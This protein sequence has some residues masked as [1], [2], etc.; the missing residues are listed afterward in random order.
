MSTAPSQV[1]RTRDDIAA[2][3]SRTL[4][5]L[6]EPGSVFEIRA[7]RTPGQGTVSGYYTDIAKCARDVAERLDGKAPAVY[8]TPNPVQ[9]DVAARAFNR[10]K[11]RADVTTQDSEIVRRRWLLIDPDP[12]RPPGISASEAEHAEALAR[13]EAI[14]EFLASEGWP[15]PIRADS[16]NGAHLLY[17]IDLPNDK[18]SAALVAGVLHALARAFDDAQV[19]VDTSVANAARIWKLYPTLVCKGDSTPRR[20]HRR[21][22]LLSAPEQPE[23]VTR[24]TLVALCDEM[25]VTMPPQVQVR[26]GERWI[27]DANEYLRAHGIEVLSERIAANARKWVLRACVWNPNHTDHS[28]WVMQFTSDGVIAAGCS[29]NSCQGKRW[30]DFRDV[31]EPGWRHATS[32][33]SSSPSRLVGTGS[34]VQGTPVHTRPLLAAAG[35]TAEHPGKQSGTDAGGRVPAERWRPTLQ[36]ATDLLNK[37]LP[38]VRWIV[39]DIIP[40]GLTLLAAKAKKGKS[41]MM[42]HVGLSVALGAKALGM[43]QTE[44]C[45]VLYLALEDNERRMQRRM[46]KMLEADSKKP[47]GLTIT[48]EWLPLDRGGANELETYLDAHRDTHLVIVDTLHHVRTPSGGVATAMQ[49]TTPPVASS[50]ASRVNGRSGSSS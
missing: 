18:E 45:G 13:A 33:I 19:K 21:S 34:I 43:L 27:A 39:Q 24:A 22:R 15:E 35:G 7:P 49:R 2:E 42:L 32:A 29:H 37:D 41:T 47:D 23:V 36:T 28:A 46:R 10:L 12:V 1:T 11:L 50:C 5:L 44:K 40:E 20:P 17:R 30:Q 9:P 38:P 25:Q 6:V 3:V 26:P 4:T 48:Y 16:G 14:A 31:V 8:V